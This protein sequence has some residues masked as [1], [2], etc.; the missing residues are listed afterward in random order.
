MR[1]D[2]I[3]R[4]CVS[5]VGLGLTLNPGHAKLLTKRQRKRMTWF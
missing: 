4:L 1:A 5:V 3:T 2:S